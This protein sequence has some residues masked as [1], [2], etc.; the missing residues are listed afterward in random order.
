MGDARTTLGLTKPGG[1]KSYRYLVGHNT[2]RSLLSFP[3]A[4]P[5]SCPFPSSPRNPAQATNRPS[6]R[7]AVSTIIAP[8]H[9]V[10]MYPT[11]E[12][13]Q[14]DAL[15]GHEPLHGDSH[16]RRR[17]R[18]LRVRDRQL[19]RADAGFRR[20]IRVVD[21]CLRPLCHRAARRRHHRLSSL[22]V[23]GG[24]DSDAGSIGSIR[25]RWGGDKSGAT[26]VASAGNSRRAS[27]IIECDD[28]RRTENAAS[29]DG[30]P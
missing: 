17:D 2:D 26:I 3:I 16:R 1:V 28:R 8:D 30:Q 29:A 9:P 27:R 5:Y 20:A 25:I 6:H 13:V 24:R 7:I 11:A 14:R 12:K 4:D 15:H 18:L 19:A 23:Q 10:R 22:L 21:P